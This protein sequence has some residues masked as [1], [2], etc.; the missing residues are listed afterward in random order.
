MAKAKL[1]ETVVNTRRGPTLIWFPVR[2]SSARCVVGDRA[3]GLTVALNERTGR[4]MAIAIESAAKAASVDS[5]LEDHAHVTIGMAFRTFDAAATAAEKYARRWQR[6]L[7]RDNL[8]QC[9]CDTIPERARKRPR[10]RPL[11]R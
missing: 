4:F 8:P 5:I 11:V 1:H 2:Q 7:S 9:A 3:L 10:A 6:G